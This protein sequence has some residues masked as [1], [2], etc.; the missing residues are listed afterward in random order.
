MISATT[1]EDVSA[2]DDS[3]LSPKDLR[4]QKKA[5]AVS[6]QAVETIQQAMRRNRYEPGGKPVA[7]RAKRSTTSPVAPKKLVFMPMDDPSDPK[8]HE[9]NRKQMRGAPGGGDLQVG[10]DEARGRCHGPR[11]L[12]Y[13]ESGL[14]PYHPGAP[15]RGAAFLSVGR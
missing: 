14:V 13:E 4:V 12:S 10:N 5:T 2:A 9:S 3:I 7:K 11:L 8:W 1:K 15:D 6:M